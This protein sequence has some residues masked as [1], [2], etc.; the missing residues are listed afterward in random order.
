[1]QEKV[2]FVKCTLQNGEKVAYVVKKQYLCIEFQRKG[3]RYVKT[4]TSIKPK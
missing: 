1:M 2:Y 3:K 4:S